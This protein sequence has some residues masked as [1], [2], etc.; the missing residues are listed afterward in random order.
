MTQ[1]LSRR[2]ARSIP[3]P[4]GNSPARHLYKAA[5]PLPFPAKSVFLGGTVVA[6]SK[7]KASTR[8]QTTLFTAC[9]AARRRA[10][11]ARIL[12]PTDFSDTSDSAL[13]YARRV[14]E[15]FG[16]SVHL[17]HVVEGPFAAAAAGAEL[18]VP[19]APAVQAAQF[20]EAKA[21]L[22]LRLHTGEGRA[23]GETSEIVTGSCARAILDVARDRGFDL[24]V[25]GTHGRSGMAHLLLGSVAEKVV[26]DATCPVLTVH[27]APPVPVGVRTWAAVSATECA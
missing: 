9:A 25:M 13:E 22:Q 6:V 19:D 27:E 8:R 12:V 4:T 10:M 16:S 21:R 15:R 18:Y 20:A 26:R 5:D 3:R 14:A 23:P 17:L 1:C 24:I 2:A 7:T 11:F